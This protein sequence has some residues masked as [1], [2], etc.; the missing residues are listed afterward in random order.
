MNFTQKSFAMFLAV[1]FLMAMQIKTASADYV[2]GADDALR[3]MVYGYEDLKTETRVSTD[4]RISFPLIGEVIVAGKTTFETERELARLLKS[5][6]FII[7]PQVTVMITEYKSQQVSVLGQV[8]SPGRYNLDSANTLV[9]VIASAG[10]I[11]DLGDEKVIV[12]HR[13]PAGDVT[14]NV[15]AIT[16]QVVNL[17]EIFESTKKTDLLPV[18][19]GDII[20]IP[21]APM[22]YIYGEVQHPGSYRVESKLTV[23]Q[24]LS[25]G[26]GLTN[27]GTE[28]DMV[29]KRTTEK[30]GVQ[31]IDVKLTDLVQKD[32]VIV[33]DERWF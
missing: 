27:R 16:R 18:Q 20:Y 1:F 6:G 23:A 13:S 3:I 15:G 29:I 30:M 17:R 19:Q 11:T 33:I 21:K 4:G 12:A 28:R 5:G 10:G 2:I 26:G 9:D 24:A 22:F 25:L 14:S 8:H 31:T 32:D 7:D